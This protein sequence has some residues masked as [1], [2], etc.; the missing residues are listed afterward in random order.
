MPSPTHPIH[1]HDFESL[2]DCTPEHEAQL[3]E[4]AQ[5][6]ELSSICLV[7]SA[8]T[9]H[10]TGEMHTRI[11]HIDTVDCEG[12]AVP[13]TVTKIVTPH[14]T[15]VIAFMRGTYIDLPQACPV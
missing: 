13:M 14:Y 1:R 2:V 11:D 4:V 5:C 7:S 9:A 15:Q 12:D 8:T 10:P 3:I 6:L